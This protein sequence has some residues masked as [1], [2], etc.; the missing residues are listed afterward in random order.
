MLVFDKNN[1]FY[2]KKYLKSVEIIKV[3]TLDLG[4]EIGR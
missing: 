4:D 1:I 3:I 2:K